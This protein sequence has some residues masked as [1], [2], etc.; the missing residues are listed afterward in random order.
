[1]VAQ[2]VNRSVDLKLLEEKVDE[3]EAQIR[4]ILILS[5]ERS[6]SKASRSGA[7]ID[8]ETVLAAINKTLFGKLG[9]RQP[10]DYY[11][12][13]N[14][15]LPSVLTK[16]EGQPIALS[17]LYIALARRLGLDAR[18]VNAPRHFIVAVS[19]EAKTDKSRDEERELGEPGGASTRDAEAKQGMKAGVDG[20]DKEGS[21]A[22]SSK[23]RKDYLFVD[24]FSKGR[25]F[26]GRS[27][28]N[29]FF[30][31]F[32]G[33]D[34]SESKL[35]P[36]EDPLIFVRMMM[37]LSNS[38]QLALRNLEANTVNKIRYRH[39]Y[40]LLTSS[41]YELYRICAGR[42]NECRPEMCETGADNKK[43]CLQYA[44][45]AGQPRTSEA[46][47]LEQFRRNYIFSRH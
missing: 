27:Q 26:H 37:N 43:R 3:I 23:P 2:S 1:M 35:D 38:F 8:V 21:D 17:V 4:Q 13:A 16:R 40:M 12:V 45:F 15:L 44:P 14:N 7:S 11:D 33:V 24:V 18:G 22:S 47:R 39:E 34:I 46:S 32:V 6:T 36:I 9:F 42:Y 29:R 30:S 41:I 19:T 31:D 20:S 10:S 25:V 28:L 5:Q